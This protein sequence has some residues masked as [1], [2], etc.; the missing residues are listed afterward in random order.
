M[1]SSDSEDL[2]T[3]ILK[4]FHDKKT[5][6]RPKRT[7]KPTAKIRETKQPIVSSKICI[8]IVTVDKFCCIL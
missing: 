7:S 4:T 5:K 6:E 8:F 2:D 1:S 3:I